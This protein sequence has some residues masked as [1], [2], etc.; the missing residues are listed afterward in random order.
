MV[1]AL[2]S[3]GTALT[4]LADS[5]L[6]PSS[7]HH[8]GLAT[9]SHSSSLS[10]SKHEG[11]C[12]GLFI[13]FNTQ[14]RWDGTCA[15]LIMEPPRVPATRRAPSYWCSRAL[16]GVATE[17]RAGAAFSFSAACLASILLSSGAQSSSGQSVECGARS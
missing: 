5:T 13:N 8:S 15:V 14:F 3:F 12:R 11:K 7:L 2:I 17:P 6:S 4:T 1:F 9:S 10:R 16:L